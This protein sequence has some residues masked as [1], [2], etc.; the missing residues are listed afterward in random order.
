MCVGLLFAVAWMS[1][2]DPSGAMP[3][4]NTFNTAST[5]APPSVNG[6]P[7]STALTGWTAEPNTRGTIDIIW[8]SVS[9]M[10]LCA[11][12]SLCLNV[13]PREWRP[14]RQVWQK[15]LLACLCV[16]GPEFIFQLALGQWASARR[17]VEAFRR[18]GY[19]TWTLSHAFFADMGGFVLHP[20]DWVPFPVNAKQIHYLVTEGYIPFSAIDLEPE[21]IKEKNKGDALA[22]C[23]A[24]TQVL[25]FTINCSMRWLQR[26]EVTTLELTTLGFIICTLGTYFCWASK[27]KDVTRP[28]VLRPSQTL[29]AILVRAGD[30]AK[31]PYRNTPLDFVGCDQ[32]SWTLYWRYWLNLLSSLH[33][34]LSSRQRPLIK[35]PDDNF[36]PPSLATVP[37]LCL[38]QLGS[39]AIHLLGWRSVFPTVI[40][41]QLWKVSTAVLLGS[42]VVAWLTEICVWRI[43][44][45]AA[46]H[47]KSIHSKIDFI[48]TIPP[49]PRRFKRTFFTRLWNN[50][51][52]NDPNLDVP[53]TALLPMT[54]A[55]ASYCI[56]RGYILIQDFVNLRA[57]PQ[58]VYAQVD[59]SVY[60]PHF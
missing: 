52:D 37:V 5:P 28:F 25:W 12:T 3:V 9:T 30:N 45:L 22:R 7:N 57:Q 39:A 16:L 18:S 36:P 31:Y 2:S 21:A 43:P 50:S 44:T 15:T 53:I 48:S 42:V 49:S 38:V 35:I 23:I 10:I 59:W 60:W 46:S 1:Y 47:A 58:S 8:S 29:A 32:W 27:P 51:P 26:Y 34:V 4:N 14:W 6:M 54:L 56:V 19:S 24:V 13:P 20:D 17:S 55:G 11:W 40:E 41:S 33:I